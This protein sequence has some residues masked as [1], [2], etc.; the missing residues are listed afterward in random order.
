MGSRMAWLR[1][2]ALAS[3]VVLLLFGPLLHGEAVYDDRLNFVRN[4]SLRHGDVVALLTEPFFRETLPYWRPVS[5]LVMA[6]C[7]H[8]G[9]LFLVHLLA[10][11]L[12]AANIVLVHGLARRWFGARGALLAAAAFLV[13][14]VHVESLGWASA[15]SGPLSATWVLLAFRAALVW[16]ERAPM[17]S[18]WPCA[19]WLALA[20]LTKE[21]SIVAAPLVLLAAR[22]SPTSGPS[23]RLRSLAAAMAVLLVGVLVARAMVL[24]AP[25]GGSEH[26]GDEA[27]IVH[28]LAERVVVLFRLLG[29]LVVPFPLTTFRPSW[30]VVGELAGPI[31]IAAVI[32]AVV[33]LRLLLR[34]DTRLRLAALLVVV[35]FVPVAW[36]FR[37]VGENPVADRFAYLPAVG[38]ALLVAALPRSRLVIGLVLVVL[39][40]HATIVRGHLAVWRDE[41]SLVAQGCRWAPEDPVPMLLLG[42]LHLE[43]AQR[44]ETPGALEAARTAYATAQ[45]LA[46]R[47]V[48]SGARRAASY[49]AA[50]EVGLA[51]C[52]ML[53]PRAAGMPDPGALRARF[54]A[55]RDADEGLTG[56]W[57]GLGVAHA[58]DG[59]F[60]PARAAFERAI[61]IDP[62]CPE[63]WFNLGYLQWQAGRSEAAAGSL[64]TAMRWDPGLLRA[65]ELLAHIE[66]ER[67]LRSM[68]AATPLSETTVRRGA[69]QR[70]HRRW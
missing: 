21:A 61:R 23:P 42:N 8:A 67:H 47:G 6:A 46:S 2:Y 39:A 59:A 57:V 53:D 16:R 30:P 63:A 20:T 9:G 45:G 11:F 43:V 64:R 56:A 4:P 60:E 55:A 37:I 41:H 7:H 65:A 31:V 66:S 19:I 12:H 62:R 52:E 25:F 28:G 3:A 15:L 32:A 10:L 58:L 35:P 38:L 13:H 69:G 22:A 49:W 17:S 70:H 36:M 33:G 51:W 50:A 54:A 18:P 44:V 14:P 27:S 29:L 68:H 26:Y 24:P 1:A 34:C 5:S 40:T 48:A